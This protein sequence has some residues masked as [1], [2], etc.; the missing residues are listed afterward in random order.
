MLAGM[1]AGMGLLYLPP[2]SPDFN[3]IEQ[4]CAKIKALLRRAVPRSFDGICEALKTI[5]DRF[6]PSECS[7]YIRHSG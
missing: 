5:L 7:N 4:V 1:E 2:H 6:K 3:P